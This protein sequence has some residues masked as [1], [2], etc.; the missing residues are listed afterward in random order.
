[1]RVLVVEDELKLAK[2]IRQ[3]LCE[4]GL[5]ADV[6]VNG[7]DALSMAPA[8]AYDVIVLDL[9][10]FGI[11]GL[12]TCRDYENRFNLVEVYVRYLREKVDPR[13]AP[14]PSRSP[15][16][17]PA[18]GPRPGSPP[19]RQVWRSPDQ[20]CRRRWPRRHRGP[21]STWHGAPGRR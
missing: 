5:L 4:A 14:N 9:N 1:M 6:A 21:T 17:W 3:A 12:E 2:L 16:R 10:L 20:R 13:P 11:D 8:N 19:R 18:R 15:R 7:E